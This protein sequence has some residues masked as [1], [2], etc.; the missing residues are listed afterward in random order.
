MQRSGGTTRLGVV[1]RARRRRE[2]Q[3]WWSGARC[4]AAGRGAGQ[5]ST[6]VGP[7]TGGSATVGRPA[8]PPRNGANGGRRTRG[9]SAARK[10]GSITGT[11]SGP[12]ARGAASGA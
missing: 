3:G 6:S 8:A 7:A 11:A 5:C 1:V 10:A 12:T 2:P 4:G 9:I